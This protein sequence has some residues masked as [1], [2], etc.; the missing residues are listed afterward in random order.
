MKRARIVFLVSTLDVG[1]AENVLAEVVNGL[2]T[3]RFESR[4]YFLREP[5]TIGS[6]LLEGGVEGEHSMEAFRGDP[7]AGWRLRGA[8]RRFGPDV[9][10][11]LDH[12]NAVF[13]GGLCKESGL[14]P[15]W[16][17]GSH[18]TG[19]VGGHSFSLRDRMFLGSI[20][21]LIA[22]SRSHASYLSTVE[23]IPRARISIIENGIDVD[24][25]GV[26]DEG[27]VENVRRSLG[28]SPN[29]RVVIMVASL[30]P[31][32]GHEAL[33]EATTLLVADGRTVKVLIVGDGPRRAELESIREAR[34]LSDHV[35]FLGERRDVREL[36]HV[37]DVL[38]LPSHPVVE[39]LP[40]CVLE[41]MAAGV[42]VVASAVGSLPDLIEDRVNGLLI[43]P[44]D[45]GGLRR[46]ICHIIDESQESAD[47]ARRARETV[48]KRYTSRRMVEGYG[49]LFESLVA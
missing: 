30:R 20:D 16:V 14:T 40:L 2:P 7:R 19:R 6:S 21:R 17:V 32:K 47:M 45:V 42:P 29:D 43:G 5:G 34:G 26:R 25:Y 13:W 44:A 33:L 36:L 4:L 3:E 9:L 15:R 27:S 35:A 38:A 12:H 48:R 41:A 1:G 23:S 24:Y 22:L 10:F 11:S 39:T 31:E 49:A 18:S 37:A 28:L 46:A 8:L